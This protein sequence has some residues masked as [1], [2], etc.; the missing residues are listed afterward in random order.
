LIG[1]L[2]NS[3]GGGEMFQGVA[4]EYDRF[5]YAT[6]RSESMP[7]KGCLKNCNGERGDWAYSSGSRQS[8]GEKKKGVI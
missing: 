3:S 4:G 8:A 5:G 7:N 1:E 6:G 2:E